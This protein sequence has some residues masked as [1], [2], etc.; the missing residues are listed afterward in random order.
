MHFPI[1]TLLMFLALLSCVSLYL[2]SGVNFNIASEQYSERVSNRPNI[3]TSTNQT[4]T[5]HN[6]YPH[7]LSATV[8]KKSPWESNDKIPAN[9]VANEN[10]SFAEEIERLIKAF[11]LLYLL[12]ISFI[13]IKSLTPAKKQYSVS[14]TFTLMWFI[15]YKASLL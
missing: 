11:C 12:A 2:D 9:E 14:S 10:T 15:P 5:V 7:D 1:I 4:P 13:K 6:V 8:S 3:I